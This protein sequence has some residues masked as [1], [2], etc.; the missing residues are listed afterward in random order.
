MKTILSV[1]VSVLL[2]STVASAQAIVY[3]PYAYAQAQINHAEQVVQTSKLVQQVEHDLQMIAQ[4]RQQYATMKQA[5]TALPSAMLARE[6]NDLAELQTLVNNEHQLMSE[7]QMYD[8]IF[9]RINPGYTPQ[10]DFGQVYGQLQQNTQTAAKRYQDVITAT[11]KAQSTFQTQ[12]T[13]NKKMID[14]ANASQSP[15]QAAIAGASL[16]QQTVEQLQKLQTLDSLRG[17]M[18]IQYYMESEADH[19][20]NKHAADTKN[21]MDW[22]VNQWAQAICPAGLTCPGIKH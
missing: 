8:G 10:S 4:L 2:T 16:A 18:E 13:N 22:A 3:D 19:A 21:T 5:V 17:Q 11:M 20:Q 1:L 6:R 9:K 15:Q 14:A 12:S 7:S